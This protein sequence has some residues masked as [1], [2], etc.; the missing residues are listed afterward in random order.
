MLCHVCRLRVGA[1]RR[2][3]PIPHCVYRTVTHG[4]RVASVLLSGSV[5]CGVPV[6]G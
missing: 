4:A 1:C 5:L 6:C 2:G 3:H